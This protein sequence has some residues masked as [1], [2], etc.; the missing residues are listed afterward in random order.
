MYQIEKPVHENQFSG[1][2]DDSTAQAQAQAQAQGQAGPTR[3]L[4]LKYNVPPFMFTPQLCKYYNCPYNLCCFASDKTYSSSCCNFLCCARVEKPNQAH[5][6]CLF[7]CCC[8][9]CYDLICDCKCC[10]CDLLKCSM[11]CR[12]N[13]LSVCMGDCCGCLLDCSDDCIKPIKT[14]CINFCDYFM[15]REG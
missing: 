2:T 6:K 5:D 15:D 8:V 1:K 9:T 14:Q 13:C 3:E 7:E 12:N 10:A 4:M 11:D